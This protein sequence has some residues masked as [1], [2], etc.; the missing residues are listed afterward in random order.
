MVIAQK[1]SCKNEKPPAHTIKLLP[2][3]PR[4]CLIPRKN[5]VAG[6]FLEIAAAIL[7]KVRLS[8]DLIYRFL[9]GTDL[10]ASYDF[11]WVLSHSHTPKKIC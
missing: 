3:S 9:I 10:G 5:I 7:D 8:E 2:R 11:N 4:T 6:V 1:A